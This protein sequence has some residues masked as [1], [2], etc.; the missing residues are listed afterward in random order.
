MCKKKFNC[1]FSINANSIISNKNIDMISIASYDNHHYSQIISALK[2]KKHVFR[3]S[4]KNYPF[5]GRDGARTGAA[6]K[7]G[8]KDTREKTL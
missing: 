5:L 7:V 8:T 3:F 6:L 1:D 4:V 2:N